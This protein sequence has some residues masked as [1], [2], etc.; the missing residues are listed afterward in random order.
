M[1]HLLNRKIRKEVLHTIAPSKPDSVNVNKMFHV[2]WGTDGYLYVVDNYLGYVDRSMCIHAIKA[3]NFLKKN[4]AHLENSEDLVFRKDS[5]LHVTLIPPGK[6]HTDA[7]K[8][9]AKE[10]VKLKCPVTKYTGVA[11]ISDPLRSQTCDINNPLRSQTN[12]DPRQLGNRLLFLS[13]AKSSNEEWKQVVQN[14][15]KTACVRC[16]FNP[17]GVHVTLGN[18]KGDM[19][20][21]DKN[22]TSK[23]V[24]ADDEWAGL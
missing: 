20:N 2:S 5:L 18:V 13:I 7:L 24:I 16:A 22:A 4:N 21:F 6:L 8:A 23:W 14:A 3:A 10:L 17:D 12:V 11:D 9:V 19:F 1:H 15:C